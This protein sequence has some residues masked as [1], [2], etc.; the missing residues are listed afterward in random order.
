MA[1]IKS[2]LKQNGKNLAI[3]GVIGAG[4]YLFFIQKVLPNDMSVLQSSL[5]S[6]I[7]PVAVDIQSLIFFILLGVI[8]TQLLIMRKKI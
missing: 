3:G 1:D 6:D 2:Y 7:I 8:V 5:V 4:F